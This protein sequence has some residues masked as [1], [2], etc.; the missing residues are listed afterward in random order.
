MRCTLYT[1]DPPSRFFIRSHGTK[2]L[3]VIE[4]GNLTAELEYQGRLQRADDRDDGYTHPRRFN[5]LF[6]RGLSGLH[7]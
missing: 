3:I 5:F 1:L 4:F 7:L 2:I 6:G